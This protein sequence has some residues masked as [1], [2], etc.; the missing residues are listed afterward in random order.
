MGPPLV[1]EAHN[2][3]EGREEKEEEGG[4]MGDTETNEGWERGEWF[5]A[6]P[7]VK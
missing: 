2:D 1:I 3:E 5:G 6:H 7:R 4:V